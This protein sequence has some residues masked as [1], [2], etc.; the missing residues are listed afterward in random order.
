MCAA[1][2]P[3]RILGCSK[4]VDKLSP[5]L[6]GHRTPARNVPEAFRRMHLCAMLAG[7]GWQPLSI[8]RPPRHRFSVVYQFK[9]C[10]QINAT[11]DVT[12]ANTMC[13]NVNCDTILR[14]WMR[15]SCAQVAV[16][17]ELIH[18]FWYLPCSWHCGRMSAWRDNFLVGSFRRYTSRSGVSTN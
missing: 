5:R 3:L 7:F 15:W 16:I 6:T 4:R 17:I 12:W 14:T 11:L 1:V 8:H 13:S 10:F 2:F 9:N 18:P